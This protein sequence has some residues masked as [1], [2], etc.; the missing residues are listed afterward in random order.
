VLHP[1]R[2]W[3][4]IDGE[5]K[6][7]SKWREDADTAITRLWSRYKDISVT[8]L[9]LLGLPERELTGLAAWRTRH[10]HSLTAATA[11]TDEYTYWVKHV[12]VGEGCDDPLAYWK[13]RRQTYP[14]L[15]PI[16]IDVFTIV[17]MSSEPER[18][19]SIA[20]VMAT[21]RRN[22]LKATTLQA[23]QCLRWWWKDKVINL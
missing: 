13:A 14:R 10:S 11:T 8:A 20:G 19:F 5:W 9:S 6:D 17:A 4:W 3:Q 21:D 7:R 1:R 2:K 12:P 18:V 22:W 23:A 16:A 15:S